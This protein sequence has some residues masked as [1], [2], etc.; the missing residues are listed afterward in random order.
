M[1][2][3]GVVCDVAR[4]SV[5]GLTS[6]ILKRNISACKIDRDQVVDYAERKGATVAEVERWLGQEFELRFW[7]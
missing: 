6:P 4:L 1:L 3:T 5:S 7:A 2:I